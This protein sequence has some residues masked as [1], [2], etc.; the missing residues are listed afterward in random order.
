MGSD[1]YDHPDLYD[2]LVP[3]GAHVP[4]DV[5]VA[6]PQAGA[7]LELACGTGPLTVPV[8]ELGLPAMGLDQS[9]AC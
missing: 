2:A 6:R 9:R 1:P 5:D 3:V 7:V 4:F 8:A